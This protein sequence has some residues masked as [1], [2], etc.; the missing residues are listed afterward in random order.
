MMAT[1]IRRLISKNL[2]RSLQACRIGVEVACGRAREE[3]AFGM[4]KETVAPAVNERVLA[5]A[6]SSNRGVAT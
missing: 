6:S 4:I 1:S 5:W 3:T 2:T